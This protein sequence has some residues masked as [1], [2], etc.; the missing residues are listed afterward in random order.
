[1]LSNHTVC[2]LN[3]IC[4]ILEKNNENRRK[5]AHIEYYLVLII[6]ITQSNI[7]IILKHLKKFYFGILNA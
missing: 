3:E 1:M 6:I 2:L 4:N 5:G 7:I